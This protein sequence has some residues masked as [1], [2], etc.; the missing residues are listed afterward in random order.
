MSKK[1]SIF[2]S[3]E[4]G[5]GDLIET[6]CLPGYEQMALDMI[7]LEKSLKSPS[8]ALTIRF[9]KWEGNWLSIGKH[10]KELPIKW[11]NLEN[12]GKLKIVRRP[13]GGKAVLHGGGLTY[14][15][16]WSNPPIKKHKSY[17]QAC[18]W[19]ING[20]SELGME[21]VFGDQADNCLKD[22]CFATS[23]T[24]DLVDKTGNKRIGS[25]QLWRHG[26]LLQ[27]GEMLLDP[28]RELWK[29]V[30]NVNPPKPAPCSIPREGLENHLKEKIIECWP[31]INWNS[32]DLSKKELIA[33]KNY[34]KS[35]CLESNVPSLS[36]I[37]EEIIDSTTWGSAISNG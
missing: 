25:A 12:Q 24:A 21:L 29:E 23:T 2:Y 32:R 1:E 36:T 28:P 5:S 16:V 15:L 33:A 27:H 13:S 9:Y 35:Y 19:L 22:N 6:V 26:H 37:P 18:E 8:H 31:E 30:F 20:F 34:S 3:S 10:Q 14:S 11:K 7:L 17:L 4:I